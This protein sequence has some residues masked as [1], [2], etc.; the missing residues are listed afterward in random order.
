[1]TMVND[2][3]KTIADASMSRFQIIAVTITL[4]LNALDGFDVLSISIAA[5]GIAS[6]WGIGRDA[7]GWVLTAELVGMAVG[8]V[9]LGGVADRI[10]R[11]PMILACISVMAVGMV[12]VTTTTSLIVLCIYRVI[13]GFGIGGMLAAINAVAAEYSN[14]RRKHLCVSLMAVGYP[15]GVAVG[16]IVSGK[17]LA[18]YDWRSVF[19][20]GAAVTTLII[21]FVYFCVPET[22][23][24]LVRKQPHG[25]LEKIN[26]TLQRM[27]H[28]PVAELPPLMPETKQSSMLS[29]LKPKY[30]AT[31]VIVAGAYF[32]HITTFYFV[33]KWMPPLM[34]S[35]FGFGQSQGATSLLWV[36]LGGALGG[37]VLGLLTMKFSLKALTIAMMLL[38]A[39][40]VAGIGVVDHDIT[41][42]YV[43]CF[44]VGFCTNAVIIGMYAIIAHVYPTSLRATGTG[45]SI[46]LGR[47]GAVVGPILAGYMLQGGINLSAVT[48]IMGGGSL[49]AAGLLVFLKLNAAQPVTVQAQA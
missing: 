6:E 47:G 39:F 24:W 19:Y 5:T 38:S 45:F 16:S 46:G 27:G 22:I 10:G 49:M 30:L 9:V 8:S 41:Q 12:L 17:L 33:A 26:A 23:H 4:V 18:H 7:L 13:T 11:R 29:I 36:S 37:A 42:I 28:A 25:A 20:L 21:P 40:L 15:L 32:F 44:C 48:L 14:T 3:I 43:L 35:E 2:P 1:M 34:V 31:T